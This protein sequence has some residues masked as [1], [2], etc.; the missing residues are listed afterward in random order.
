MRPRVALALYYFALLGALGFFWPFLAAHLSGLGLQPWEIGAISALYPLGTL[1]APPL[2]GLCADL[3][4]ARVW[5]LRALTAATAIAF[6]AFVHFGGTRP[7]LVAAVATFALFR[8]PLSPMADAAAVEHA[9]RHGGSYGAVRLWGSVGFLLAAL[10]GGLLLDRSG[11][12]VVMLAALAALLA[13]A[14]AVW[15]VPAPPPRAERGALR[16]AGRLLASGDFWLFLATVALGQVAHSAYDS[17][18]SLHL[19]RLG[20]GGRFTGLAWAVGV[21]AEIGLLAVSG[22]LIGR[23]GG[24]RLLALAFAVG[25]A[26]WLLLAEVRHPV[27]ILALQ[28]LHAVSF[29]LYYVAG[30]TLTREQASEE[31]QTAAQGLFSAAFALGG[32]VGMPL[33]GRLFERLGSR[34][35]FGTA[36]AV[37]GMACACALLWAARRRPAT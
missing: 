11:S 13:A 37:A 1:V 23:F 26:R 32:V 4:R 5:L 35:M 36:A 16:A 24:A 33:A 8:A 27:L 18:F 6:A 12:H 20:C 15:A 29:A 21:V 7:A 17:F 34:A 19:A 14:V 22:R 9:R 31:T 3:L 25:A 30:V 10:A 28:P 2:A